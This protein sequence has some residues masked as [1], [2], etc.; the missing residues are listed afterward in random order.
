MMNAAMR[1]KKTVCLFSLEMGS[2]Q[3][4]DRILA[5]TANVP[6]HKITK[7]NLDEADFANL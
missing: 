6:M 4:V 3:I 1:A 2:E 5:T 7:G